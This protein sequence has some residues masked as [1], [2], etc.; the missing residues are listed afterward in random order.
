MEVHEPDP[1][2]AVFADWLS[3]RERGEGVE[4]SELLREHPQLA[5]ELSVLHASWRGLAAA[6]SPDAPPSLQERIERRFGAASA[7]VVS[8]PER[9]RD[10]ADPS[11]AL[12]A[13]LSSQSTRFGRYCLRGEVAR[14][15][16]GAILKVWDAELHRHLAMK[17]ILGQADVRATGTTPPVESSKVARFLEEAQV[18][19]QLDHPGIVPVHELGLDPEGRLYFTMK[20]VKGESLHQVF[21][22]VREGNGEWTPTRAL[23]VLHKVC[24]AM[25]Y[26]HD[27]GVIHRDLKPA[28]VMVGKFGAVYVMDWGLARIE[29]RE[30]GKDLRIREQEPASVQLRSVRGARRGDAP[31]S[32]LYT[33]DGDVVGTPNYMPPE[34]A[35]GQVQEIGPHSDVY[36][37]GAMLYHLLAGA[38]PYSEPGV[39]L[40]GHAILARVQQGPPTPLEELVPEVPAELAAICERAMSRS[41]TERYRDMSELAEDLSAYLQGR[42]VRAHETGAWA[43]AR[44]WVQRNRALAASLAAAVLLLVAGLT[45]SLV[46]KAR[47]SARAAELLVAN[48][49]LERSNLLLASARIESDRHAAEAQARAQDVLKLSASRTLERLESQADELWPPAPELVGAYR[50]WMEEAERLIAELPALRAP[51]AELERRALP[52]TAEDRARERATHPRLR[53][54]EQMRVRSTWTSRMA[55]LEPWP[56]EPETEAE[57]AAEGLPEEARRLDELAR[58]SLGLDGFGNGNEM[59]ALLLVRRALAAADPGEEPAIRRTLV[60]A[61]WKLGRFD[62]GIEEAKHLLETGGDRDRAANE[63]LLRSLVNVS[64]SWREA[65]G[66][67]RASRIAAARKL[68]RRVARLDALVSR[69]REWRFPDGGSGA[70]G[71]DLWWHDHMSR[72]VDALELFADENDGPV[73][74]A[75]E[76]HGMG[77]AKRLAYASTIV[78]RSVS[79]VRAGPA[80]SE[81]LAAIARSERYSG[82][83]WPAAGLRPQLGLLP[84]GP[85]PHSGLWEFAELSTGEPAVR[86]SDGRLAIREETGL[87]FVLLPGGSFLMGSQSSDPA[88]PNYD[89]LAMPKEAPVHEVVLSPFFVSKYEMTQGQW[90]RITSREPSQWTISSGDNGIQSFDLTHP[91]ERV[92]WHD[93][94]ETMRRIGLCLPTESQWEYACRGGTSTAWWTGQDVKSLDGKVNLADQTARRN[95]ATWFQ[96]TEWPDLTDGWSVHAPV[97]SFP[98]NAFGLHEMAGNVWEHCFGELED[99]TLPSQVDPS[100]PWRGGDKFNAGRGGGF[101]D[102]PTLLRSGHRDAGTPDRRGTNT[103]LRPARKLDS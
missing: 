90:L 80:W 44:K 57:I 103:G 56:G 43:E 52:Q 62:E 58:A 16:M 50:A 42:V 72:L 24:E 75:S 14:G 67:I 37:L 23:H 89:P 12:I 95:Q 98:A 5:R 76:S 102:A 26:A 69:R 54:L 74:G 29:G 48:T 15:G 93:S 100:T 99:Y 17:V 41:W 35:L 61:C 3:L 81:A 8:L 13:Q 32:P 78:E 47:A 1:A 7:P 59:R 53:E 18:T 40:G 39:R 94:T 77:V 2:L 82:A 55:G 83:K 85:D 63:A 31:D 38:P 10:E 97:G 84:I 46:F 4:F 9:G 91:V 73:W 92:S 11:S 86:G 27:K 6:W 96:G 87:V 22:H 21:E 34:Q 25:A 49:D 64:S 28:N 36:A 20:L 70:E 45:A 68:A 101:G 88:G 65:D 79:G 19:G 71:G 66:R 33:L 60:H 30:D 51:L